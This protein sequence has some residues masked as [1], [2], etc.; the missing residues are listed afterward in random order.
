MNVRKMMARLNTPSAKLSPGGGKGAQP[1][2]TPQDIAGAL[3]YVRH[4][5]RLACE[6]FCRAW[7]PD[8]AALDGGQALRQ[9]FGA[10]LYD[11]IARRDRQ[12]HTA[13]MEL[14]AAQQALRAHVAARTVKPELSAEVDR[15]RERAEH[16]RRAQWPANDSIVDR[17]LRA[18]ITEVCEPNTC[19]TC[20][21]T[22][23]VRADR[24]VITCP[25]CHG[26]GVLPTSDR[27]RARAVGCSVSTYTTSFWRPMYNF[28]YDLLSEK[29]RRGADLLSEQLTGK[30]KERAA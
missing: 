12:L 9:A 16:A 29:E 23:E 19:P 10:K 13:R 24:K 5:D 30:V 2:L 27:R 6:V 4:Q 18:A 21:G 25:D 1:T 26:H 17:V 3:G 14:L 15:A 22:G 7:W 28:S 20:E 11:E 8:G